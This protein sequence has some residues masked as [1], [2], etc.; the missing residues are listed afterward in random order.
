MDWNPRPVRALSV[1]AA[2]EFMEE[3]N[4]DEVRKDCN[5]LLCQAL[6]RVAALTGIPNVYSTKPSKSRFALPTQMGVLPLPRLS[7]PAALKR[8][9]YDEFR[10]EIPVIEWNDRH[11]LRISVQGYNTPYDIENLVEALAVVLPELRG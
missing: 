3:H 11:L 4:W 6:E 7:D 5:R 8:R 1:P 2:I 9:L 10:I